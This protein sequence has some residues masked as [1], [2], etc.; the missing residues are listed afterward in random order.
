MCFGVAR[1]TVET[2]EPTTIDLRIDDQ[3]HET[4]DVWPIGGGEFILHNTPIL[5][6]SPRDEDGEQFLLYLGD[7]IR[8]EVLAD[9]THRLVAYQQ[10][11]WRHHSWMVSQ[12]FVESKEYPEFFAEV[13]A[14]GGRVEGVM[15]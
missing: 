3:G 1:M 7:A 6:N 12:F 8:T 5:C 15:G 9:G 10:S 11:P 4:V 14:A 13:D 2:D